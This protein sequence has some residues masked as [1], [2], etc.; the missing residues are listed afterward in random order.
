M[1]LPNPANTILGLT[2]ILFL[3]SPPFNQRGTEA[4]IANEALVDESDTVITPD[5]TYANRGKVYPEKEWKVF[6]RGVD[7]SAIQVAINDLTGTAFTYQTLC[8]RQRHEKK[9]WNDQFI[10]VSNTSKTYEAAKQMCENMGGHLPEIYNQ[11]QYKNL[12]K[13]IIKL[14]SYLAFK[15]PGYQNKTSIWAGIKPNRLA[16]PLFESTGR[17]A[18]T[19]YYKDGTLCKDKYSYYDHDSFWE[20]HSTDKEAF[21]YYIYASHGLHLCSTS[22]WSTKPNKTHYSQPVI[23]QVKPQEDNPE[24]KKASYQTCLNQVELQ[25]R[26]IKIQKKKI[27]ELRQ[28]YECSNTENNETNREKR[29]VMEWNKQ[30]RQ[31]LSK[32]NYTARARR[33]LLDDDDEDPLLGFIGPFI[34]K[35]TGLET[36]KR[37]KKRMQRIFDSLNTTM[38]EQLTQIRKYVLKQSSM[39]LKMS[40]SLHMIHQEMNIMQTAEA[41]T[42]LELK[43][44]ILNQEINGAFLQLLN[45]LHSRTPFE[46]LTQAIW[47][48]LNKGLKKDQKI[49]N[50]ADVYATGCIEDNINTVLVIAIFPKTF[51]LIEVTPI[52]TFTEGK[53]VSLIDNPEFYAMDSKNNFY[54]ISESLASQCLIKLNSCQINKPLTEPRYFTCALSQFLGKNTTVCHSTHTAESTPFFQLFYNLTVYSV[55]QPMTMNFECDNRPGT[56]LTKQIRGK[57]VLTIPPG[58]VVSTGNY[59][60]YFNRQQRIDHMM[61]ERIQ[62][63]K[64][65]LYA[66]DIKVDVNNRLQENILSEMPEI[67]SLNEDDIKRSHENRISEHLII[68]AYKPPGT[69]QTVMTN[70]ISAVAILLTIMALLYLVA[71]ARKFKKRYNAKWIHRSPED[72]E[73]RTAIQENRDRILSTRTYEPKEEKETPGIVEVEPSTSIIQPRAKIPIGIAKKYTF[74][75]E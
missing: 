24:L 17:K 40:D 8:S 29:E 26:H 6:E 4:T 48:Q 68:P 50:K 53:R 44:A 66:K 47:K 37:S 27:Y 28:H 33:G 64:I 42:M 63:V 34:H 52:P 70:M 31:L 74:M 46:L 19:G 67:I 10:I 38:Q 43:F 5:F 39:T 30:N 60:Y 21:F 7:F 56:D 23:C 45:F 18:S 65:E 15:P 73:S 16:L 49:N 61:P 71:R 62:K 14:H 3:P 54:Q 55:D 13:E 9:N 75:E 2:I 57:G 51:Y 25:N 32:V 59:K 1:K 69:I 36:S 58:C 41:L 12:F 72:E 22:M 11:N 35:L 20:N